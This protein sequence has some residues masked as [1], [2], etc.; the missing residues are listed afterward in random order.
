[1]LVFVLFKWQANIDFGFGS[2][3]DEFVSSS[4]ISSEQTGALR[5]TV[6]MG[7]II[8]HGNMRARGQYRVKE[9]AMKSRL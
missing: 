6:V 4:D 3:G 1:M 9:I 7:I 2:H 5:V 8:L